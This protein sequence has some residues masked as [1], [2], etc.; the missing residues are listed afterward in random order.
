[1]DTIL[2]KK[3]KDIQS[4][5]FLTFASMPDKKYPLGHQDIPEVYISPEFDGAGCSEVISDIRK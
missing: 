1:M 4:T 5:L 3:Y 2:T